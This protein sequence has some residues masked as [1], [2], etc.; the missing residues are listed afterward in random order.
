MSEET[1]IDSP[2]TDFFFKLPSEADMPVVFADYY[3]QDYTTVVDEETGEATQVPDG[4][5]YLVE[6]T[7][8]YSIDVVGTIWEPTGE[9]ITDDGGFS[10]PETAPIDG[11]HVNFRFISGNREAIEAI[12]EQYGM[13]PVTPYQSFL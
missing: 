9:T 2:K 8:E 5:P 10:Y 13:N 11:W 3:H 12:D 7:Y 6:N 4:E 1:V